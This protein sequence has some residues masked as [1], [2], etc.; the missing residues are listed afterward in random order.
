MSQKICFFDVDGTLSQ[1]FYAV[2]FSQALYEMGLFAK[3]PWEDIKRMYEDYNAGKITYYEGGR[4]LGAAFGEGIRGQRKEAIQDAGER[5]VSMNLERVFP[6]VGPLVKMVKDKGYRPVIISGS[7][8]E[9]IEEFGN[10]INIQEVY[11][12]EYET[13]EDGT[14]T[15]EVIKNCILGETKMQVL[16]DFFSANPVDPDACAGFGDSIE[17]FPLLDT[18]GYPVAIFPDHELE[19][20]ARARGWLICKEMD[21]VLE[22]TQT[23]LP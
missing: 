22:Q 18:I 4:I 21:R 19:E 12:S 3:G 23:Y 20:K 17:D 6:F 16:D 15:G 1:G 10:I 8:L 7:A 13:G 9:V 5:F 14:Y 2:D 11:A